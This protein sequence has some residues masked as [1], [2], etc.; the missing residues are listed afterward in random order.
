MSVRCSCGLFNSFSFKTDQ[1]NC[2]RCDRPLDPNDVEAAHYNRES[3]K[4]REFKSFNNSWDTVDDT[5]TIGA[6]NV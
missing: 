1:T 6:K 3:C 2:I 4:F 5:Y